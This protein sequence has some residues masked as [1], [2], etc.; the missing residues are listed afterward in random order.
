M[1][2]TAVHRKKGHFARLHIG[3]VGTLYMRAGVLTDD[4]TAVYYCNRNA[5]PPGLCGA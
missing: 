3:E 2:V 5:R 4:L 1:T